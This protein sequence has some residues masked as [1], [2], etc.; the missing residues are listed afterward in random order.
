MGNKFLRIFIIGF[1]KALFVII[2]MLACGVGGFFGIRYY[3][4]QKNVSSVGKASEAT[5]DDVAKNLIYVWNEEKSRISYCVL[6]VFDSDSHDLTYITIPVNGQITLSAE[7][8]QKLYKISPEIPQTIKISQL[9]DYLESD[10]KVYGYGVVILENYFDIDISYYTVVASQD[11]AKRFETGKVKTGKGKVDGM[12]LK[13]DY[14]AEMAAYTDKKAL[15]DYLKEV[16]NQTK[17]NLS[18]KDKQS[19]AEAYTQV[20][21]DQIRYYALPTTMEGQNRIFDLEKTEAIFEKCNVDGNTQVSDGTDANDSL[22]EPVLKN[23]V[24][25]NST[26]TTGVAAKWSETLTE[27][28]YQVEIG[29]YDPQLEKT[30]IVVRE[31]GQ[32]EE[33]LDYFSDA[34]IHVGKVP[35]GADAQIIIGASDVSS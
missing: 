3:Y 33:F 8:F 13:A 5:R 9:H 14:L 34:E 26:D 35:D 25:L 22:S 20:Q 17:S 31:E 18:T 11:F 29:N 1:L 2:C 30:R 6:E 16:C 12:V 24:V 10:E 28:G 4:A 23:I 32:G 19:Y 27:Q 7:L 21:P 15:S